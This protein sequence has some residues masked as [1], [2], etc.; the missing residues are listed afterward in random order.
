M[1]EPTP[2]GTAQ[3]DTGNGADLNV[4]SSNALRQRA[5]CLVKF[6]AGLPSAIL[7]FQMRHIVERVKLDLAVLDGGDQCKS[8]A[9]QLSGALVFAPAVVAN[10]EIRGSDTPQIGHTSSTRKRDRGPI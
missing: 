4:V 3:P 1:L 10:P 2:L 5:G 9:Q 7:P 6:G 8:L